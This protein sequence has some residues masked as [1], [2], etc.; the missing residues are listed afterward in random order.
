MIRFELWILWLKCACVVFAAFGVFIAVFNQTPVFDVLFGNNINP[1]FFGDAALTPEM[2]RFQQWVY[3]LLGA[4]CV[5][6]GILLF[7]IVSNAYSK[8]ERWALNG[9]MFGVVA[10]FVIDEAVSIYFAVEFNAVFNLVL[11]AILLI[12]LIF[13]MRYFEKP[14]ATERR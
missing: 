14:A 12:P 6:V 9:I 10:W 11:L 5:F 2:V 3:G 1:A 7:F 8:K 4:T 13:T